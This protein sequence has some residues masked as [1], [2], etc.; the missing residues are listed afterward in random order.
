MTKKQKLALAAL[1][2]RIEEL[3][4]K[5]QIEIS[6]VIRVAR[7]ELKFNVARLAAIFEVRKD[8]FRRFEATGFNPPY[9]NSAFCQYFNVRK[10]YNHV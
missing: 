4:G 9:F 8:D 7:K 5:E 10:G 3:Y 6:T 2:Q 1:R